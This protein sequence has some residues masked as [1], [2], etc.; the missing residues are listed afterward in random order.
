MRKQ[1]ADLSDRLSACLFLFLSFCLTKVSVESS[2][3]VTGNCAFCPTKNI[4]VLKHTFA[5]PVWLSLKCPSYVYTWKSRLKYNPNSTLKF[6]YFVLCK[7]KRGS[8]GSWKFPY[9]FLKGC[10]WNSKVSCSLSEELDLG[11][12]GGS[13]T[14]HAILLYLCRSV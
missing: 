11:R 6:E 8:A 5:F 3:V 14:T 9:I 7:K 4:F 10:G 13:H 1:L 2:M 12:R